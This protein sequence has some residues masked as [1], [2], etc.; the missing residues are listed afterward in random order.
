MYKHLFV[1]VD[2]SELSQRAMEGA[3]ALASQLGARITG[4]VV[5]PDVGLAVVTPDAVV[6]A[7]RMRDHEQRNQE[8]AQAL[9][10]QFEERAKAAGVEFGGHFVASDAVDDTIAGEAERVGAD[11]IVMVTHGRGPVGEFLFGSHTKHVISRSKLP[12]LV[13][14]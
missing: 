12:V 8:H 5:E 9:L 4:F 14:H 3:I 11:M 2:G 6:Y 1:P 10:R 7:E 13:L